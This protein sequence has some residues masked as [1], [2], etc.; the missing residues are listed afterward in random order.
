MALVQNTQPAG[1]GPVLPSGAGVGFG[2]SKGVTPLATPGS[3][4]IAIGGVVSFSDVVSASA[5]SDQEEEFMVPVLAVP[6]LALGHHANT[7]A[8][9]HGA[10]GSRLAPRPR[11]DLHLAPAGRT[12]T[13]AG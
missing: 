11:R 10:S 1:T 6:F 12:P 9:T 3:K 7:G 13:C 8:I 4:V 2:P 5:S